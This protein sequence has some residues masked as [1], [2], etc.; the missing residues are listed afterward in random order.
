MSTFETD[1]CM[2]CFLK[3]AE[4]MCIDLHTHSK[5]SDGSL[6]PKELVHLAIRRGIRVLSLTDHDTVEGQAEIMLHG[7]EVGV[8]IIAGLEVTACHEQKSI[9]ILG[10][11]FNYR[12]TDLQDWLVRIQAGR[13]KR[14]TKIL[15]SLQN[16]GIDITMEE[17]D[18]F[19]AQGMA[20][21]PHIAQVLVHKGVVSSVESAFHHYLGKGKVAWHKRFSYS[22]IETIAMIHKM[23]G[24]AVLA[25]PGQL[26]AQGTTLPGLIR[27]L[28]LRGLDGLEVYYPSHSKKLKKKLLR[29][30]RELD[31]VIT[32]G[33]DYHGDTRPYRMM[34]GQNHTFCPAYALYSSIEEKIVQSQ[35]GSHVYHTCCR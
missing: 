2:A 23:G 31:L 35:K 20:G 1:F 33:S 6:T 7:A 4:N 26:D 3:Y 18:A 8:H 25:H 5:Y 19:S 17:V 10:Y 15:H 22:A 30:C 12:S 34:A 14:N 24:I 28:K 21:R 13:E 27:Q 11:G 16:I 32:G 9:H 29:L